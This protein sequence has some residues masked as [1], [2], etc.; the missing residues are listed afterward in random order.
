[1][2]KVIEAG[3]G[4]DDIIGPTQPIEISD[5]ELTESEVD[6]EAELKVTVDGGKGQGRY[7][8]RLLLTGY[9]DHA[10]NKRSFMR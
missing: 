9:F 1:M 6:G 10:P 7:A 4:D 2:H 3:A 8:V 5:E